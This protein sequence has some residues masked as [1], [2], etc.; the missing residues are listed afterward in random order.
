MPT[1]L[2]AANAISDKLTFPTPVVPR[3]AEFGATSHNRIV[4]DRVDIHIPDEWE[5]RLTRGGYDGYMEAEIGGQTGE[6]SLGLRDLGGVLQLH[7]L[8]SECL[9]SI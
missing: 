8:A 2:T 4:Y 5:C 1:H 6:K 3:G 9:L 7:N